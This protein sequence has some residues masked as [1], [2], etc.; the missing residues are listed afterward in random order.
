METRHVAGLTGLSGDP[1]PFTAR[2]VL[3]AL[4]AAARHRWNDETLA[5]RTIALQGCGSVGYHLASYLKTAGAR[6]LV[7]DV[8]EAKIELVV[9]EFDAEGIGTDE[10]YSVE[11]DVF[12]PC[13]LGGVINDET[14]P[15]F[16]VEIIAGA[17]NNQL[18]EPRHGD[19][20]SRLG[21]L[22]AP[23]YAANVGGVIN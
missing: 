3:R 20:L 9:K 21:I 11:A 7:T 8:D 15:Q 18:L 22:Y 10:I 4:Q 23:D 5:G 17:A 2:G 13:A 6:L 16:K 1:S 12:A 14:I 19:A